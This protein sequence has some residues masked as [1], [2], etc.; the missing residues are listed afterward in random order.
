[1]SSRKIMMRDGHAFEGDGV[2]IARAMKTMAFGV[3]HLSLAEYVDFV[4][5][6]ALKFEDITLDVGGANEAEKAE[7]LVQAMLGAGL[8]VAT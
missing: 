6:S 1:M 2:A 3:E 4:A 5:A 7:A 8:A